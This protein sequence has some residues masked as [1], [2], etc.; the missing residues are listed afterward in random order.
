VSRRQPHLGGGHLK[1]PDRIEDVKKLWDDI[2]AILTA[3]FVGQVD[4]VHLFLIVGLVL[5]FA[6][7]WVFILNHIRLAAAEVV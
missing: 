1:G 7:A 6:A 5:L 2:T 4:L 3:P